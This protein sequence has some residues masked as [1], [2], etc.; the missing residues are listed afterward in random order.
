VL[1]V[2]RHREVGRGAVQRPGGDHRALLAVHHQHGLL[3]RHV[4]EHARSAALELERLGVAAELDAAEL[5]ARGRVDDGERA[6]AV[7]DVETLVRG[8]EAHVVG[9]AAEIHAARFG[10]SR[11]YDG[12][13]SVPSPPVVSA[14]SPASASTATPCGSSSPAIARGARIFFASESTS[15]EPLPSAATNS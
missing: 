9:V 15:T 13:G 14:S 11:R 7:A 4:D 2:E 5:L 8:I 10:E 6:V 3:R 1:L 12:S